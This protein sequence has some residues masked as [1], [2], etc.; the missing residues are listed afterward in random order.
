MQGIVFNVNYPLYF[1]IAVFEYSR[2]LGYRMD[3]APEFVTARIEC[4]LRGP[5]RFDD[6]LEIGV[7][8]ARFGTKSVA[9]AFAAFRGEELLAEGVNTYVAVKRGTTE[10]CPL[11]PEYIERVMTFEKTPPQGK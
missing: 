9:M 10:T 8:V 11:E 3:D 5:A 1:D 7:R 4:D 2:A 6:E